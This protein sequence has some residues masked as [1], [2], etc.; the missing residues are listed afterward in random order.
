MTSLG[1]GR[2]G[3]ARRAKGPGAELAA[4]PR[5]ALV[6][7]DRYSGIF[8]LDRVRPA[9][10]ADGLAELQV[11]WPNV[12][13][14]FCE[15]RPLAEEW[16]YRYLAA[17]HVWAAHGGCRSGPMSRV[18]CR[19][20]P[21]RSGGCV[22]GVGVA[23]QPGDSGGAVEADRWGVGGADAAMAVLDQEAS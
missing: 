13:I 3:P 1:P 8:K 12:P 14:V 11:R 22:G 10:I 17:A 15:T 20:I 7:E 18:G 21:V 16:T 23:R 19:C 6:V 9:M 2:I 5:A 4:L